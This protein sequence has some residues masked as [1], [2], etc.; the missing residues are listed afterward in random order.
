M[1]EKCKIIEGNTE[2]DWVYEKKLKKKNF[3]YKL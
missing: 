2:F 1:P 3:E